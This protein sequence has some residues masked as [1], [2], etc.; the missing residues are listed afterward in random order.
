[1]T[2]LPAKFTPTPIPSRQPP[3]RESWREEAFRHFPPSFRQPVARPPRAIASARGR[4]A[5]ASGRAPWRL[6]TPRYG[7]SGSG[8][9]EGRWAGGDRPV[10]EAMR[11]HQRGSDRHAFG[12]LRRRCLRRAVCLSPLRASMPAT[13]RERFTGTGFRCLAHA[14]TSSARQTGVARSRAIGSGKS[15]RRVHRFACVRE[16]FSI[17]A[18]S[19]R[20]TRSSRFRAMYKILTQDPRSL[21][22]PPTRFRQRCV[23]ARCAAAAALR[24]ANGEHAVTSPHQERDCERR[25]NV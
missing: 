15:S 5:S 25:Q 7:S 12:G 18:T 24:C 4:S 2:T 6:G 10:S 22:P 9:W 21:P 16:V 13:P 14:F 17:A 11:P 23:R 20:P 3:H 8:P 1:M 19:A